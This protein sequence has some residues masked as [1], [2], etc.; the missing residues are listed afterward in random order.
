M[1]MQIYAF[2]LA[3][4]EIFLYN[5]M[6]SRRMFSRAPHPRVREI[7]VSLRIGLPRHP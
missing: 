7:V 6:D 5:D 3:F 2:I 4:F 1:T